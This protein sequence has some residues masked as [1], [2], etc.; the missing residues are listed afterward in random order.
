MRTASIGLVA[1]LLLVGC[2]SNR[3]T[4]SPTPT[5]GTTG[6]A[7]AGA[8]GSNGAAGGAGASGSSG[9]AGGAA[10]S[11]GSGGLAG[12]GGTPVAD[13]SRDGANTD[14]AFDASVPGPDARR[15]VVVSDGPSS[16]RQTARPLGTVPNATNGYWE[17]LPPGYGDGMKVPLMVFWHGVGEDGNGSAAGLPIVLRQGPPKYISQNQWPA[18]RPFI[19]L[20][21]QH[22]PTGCPTATEIHDFMTFAI[23]HYDVDL[24]R[25][26]LTGLSCGA[27]GSASYLGQFKGEQVVAAVLIAGFIEPA[28][29]NAGC[30]LLDQVALWVFH[31][32]ADVDA[33]IASDN[34][35]M[36][37]FIACPQ[38]R[39]EVMYHVWPG[40]D[41]VRSWEL[42]YDTALSGTIDIYSWLLTQ[43]R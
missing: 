8:S 33:P 2:S 21:P 9:A 42:T 18:A 28:Y 7:G 13:G 25:V 3:S 1:A 11:G 27:M 41:H 43:H 6:S 12:S 24:T 5:A 10:G 14:A 15:D 37:Q 35:F 16:S 34:T 20:S 22:G 23:G 32:D 31:G 4:G 40:A 36:P 29:T 30:S 19:V 17:Y 26:Y 38:P 39:K